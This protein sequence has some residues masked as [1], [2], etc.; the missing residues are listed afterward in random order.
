MT[1]QLK[2]FMRV[3]FTRTNDKWVSKMMSDF[4]W[5]GGEDQGKGRRTYEQ[6]VNQMPL[7]Q[8]LERVIKV[9][10][11]GWVFKRLNVSNNI[12]E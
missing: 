5:K 1:E 11:S 9:K 8:W 3:L 12:K 4:T 6:R 2:G 7:R 10:G